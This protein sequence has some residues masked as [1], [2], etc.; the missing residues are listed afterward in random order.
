MV[1]CRRQTIVCSHQTIVCSRQT[2]VWRQ[3]TISARIKN[4]EKSTCGQPKV[5]YLLLK[6]G[7]EKRL[8]RCAAHPGRL[9]RSTIGTRLFASRRYEKTSK[10]Q[11]AQ[12]SVAAW[13]FSLIIE[14]IQRVRRSVCCFKTHISVQ[15]VYFQVNSGALRPLVQLFPKI[16]SAFLTMSLRELMNWKYSLRSQIS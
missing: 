11:E 8:F 9:L 16:S 5:Q 12:K 3:Q 1:V 10:Q 15:A 4:A 13:M 2:T 6:K 7:E 14:L